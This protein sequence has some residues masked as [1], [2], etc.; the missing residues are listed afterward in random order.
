MALKR[1]TLRD[2]VIVQAL[3]LDFHQGFTALTGETGA[4]KSILIDALQ[5]ALGA[6]A[7]ASVV[8]EG[9][10][11]ADVCA[12][13]DCPDQL[14]TWLEEAGVEATETLLIR[15]TVDTQGKSR[16]WINGTPVTATQLRT[17]GDHLLDIHG[18]HAWQ[19][20]TRPESVRNLLDA[21]AGVSTQ[22]LLANWNQW[23][24]AQKALI[25]AQE[26][27]T[28]LQRERERLQWQIAEVQK[29]SP[30]ADE[31]EELSAKHQRASNAQTLLDAAQTTLES[32][33]GDKTGIQTLLARAQS[34]LQAH[35]NIEPEFANMAE[36]LSS[37]LAQ[38]EDV[39]HSLQAYLRH[40]DIDSQNLTELDTRMSQ[41][42]ALCKRYRCPPD[43][44]TD[45]CE[46]WQQELQQLD[47]ASNLEGLA[48]QESLSA[49]NYR[50]EAQAVSAQR[51]KAAPK[52]SKAITTAMQ[53]LGMAGGR[54]EVQL[55]A[56]AEPAAH[57]VD[58]IVFLV[59]GHPGVTPKPVG[60][61][62]SGG[63]LSRIALAISVT[64]SQLG[65]ATSLIFDEVDSG[66]GGAVAETVGQLMHQL[67]RDRQV[68]AVTHL[69]QVAACADQHMVVYKL[70]TTQGTVSDVQ[71]V[72][73]ETRVAEIARMLGGERTTETSL[74]HAREML[75]CAWRLDKGKQ[76]HGT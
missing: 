29:L 71:T 18:Q 14:H 49:K 62:A 57:G 59:A 38:V 40:T 11:K 37:S 72:Q 44:L 69:S 42:L 28:T 10:T 7:D 73:G 26:A 32:I 70:R 46:G 25:R 76:K 55:N 3:E 68:L 27:Q 15:R 6:R 43:M 75:L 60:K 61:V 67:G 36:V 65:A 54:F 63:E 33:A 23:R 20:L 12:E 24:N 35:S 66:V 53:G 8:R 22:K 30:Q 19:S 41:W 5:L 64:T 4:G 48:H 56:S 50:D 13:F 45:T 2:F 58:D 34:K 52:L 31:W 16:G 51:A 39:A 17:V 21:F 74:A 9:T 47:E 1:V